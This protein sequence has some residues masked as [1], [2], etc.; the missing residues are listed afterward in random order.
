[1]NLG[2][3]SYIEDLRTIWKHEEKEFTP[4]LAENISLL[5]EALGLDLEVISTEH[6]VGAF[7]LDILAKDTSSG[8]IVA[9]ENQLEITDHTHL[10]QILTYASGVDAKTVIWISK[11]V[12]EE[13]RKAID[14]LNQITSEEIEFFAVEVQLIKIDQSSPAPFFKV[15]ASPN[16]W[17]KEQKTKI[18]SSTGLSDRQEYFHRFFTEFLELVH[19]EIPGL[20]NSKKVAY[21]AWK[22]FPSGVSGHV[23]SI[24]FRSGN[25]F[26]CELYLDSGSKEK[27]KERFD[28]LYSHKESIEK[29]LGELSWERLDDRKACRIAVY[30]DYTNDEEILAWG[31]LKLKLFREC[32]KNYIYDNV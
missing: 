23:Y 26:S 14:W 10:G 9:I 24:A 20:T 8:N 27:N 28:C 29:A 25:R 15:K 1:M 5:G 4:W 16:D 30:I 7:S 19:K 18:T 6:D 32:F 17:S 21:D 2:K 12:R 11:E 3:L 13:H 22:S 31:I